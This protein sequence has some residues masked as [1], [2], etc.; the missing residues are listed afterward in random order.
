M[1]KIRLGI[2]GLGGRGRAMYRWISSSTNVQP[3]AA[4]DLKKELWFEKPEPP[5][6]EAPSALAAQFPEVRFFEDFEEMLD[7]VSMD[8]LLVETPARCHAS[9]CAAALSRD[10]HVYSDIPSVS[11]LQEADLLWKARN[12]SNAMLMTG[13]TTMGWGFVIALQDLFRQGLLGKPYALEAEYIHDCRNLWEATPWRKPGGENGSPEE[14]IYY[15]THGLGP[16]LSILKEDLR[17]VTA[18]STGSHM[19]GIPEANDLNTAI[20]YTDSGV[21]VKQTNSFINNAKTGNHSFRVFG[22]EGYFEH[23]SSR[24]RR[25]ATTGFSSNKLYGSRDFTELPV[26]FTP[27][28]LKQ[29][30]G[31]GGA[32]AYLWQLFEEALLLGAKT[33]PI[34]LRDG[35][36]MTIP[37]I[38]AV[39]SILNGSTPEVIHYPWDPDWDRFKDEHT[40]Q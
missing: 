3:V 7:E 21:M 14:P 18:F 17:R 9:F 11:T 13:A 31:H 10:I 40:L 28:D 38:Y 4:C 12:D 26:T 19:T 15:C 39:H 33:A 34:D 6:R 2:V 35:L 5:S 20:Y 32:D 25:P 22:T 8:V 27:H 37:G 24:G 30:F 16:L 1:K 23:L 36:R 29:V